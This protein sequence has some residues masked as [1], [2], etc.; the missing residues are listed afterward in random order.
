MLDRRGLVLMHVSEMLFRS[1]V[2]QTYSL[3]SRLVLRIPAGVHVGRVGRRLGRIHRLHLS[4][5]GLLHG[6]WVLVV[7]D[8]SVLRLLCPG[9]L[10][11]KRTVKMPGVKAVR[12]VPSLL[13]L[14]PLVDVRL[15]L[16]RD[17][18]GSRNAIL[19]FLI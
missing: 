5:V 14:S 3:G 15:V 2:R 9:L 8:W 16:G 19:A 17:G 10:G 4:V 6:H 1:L 7:G 11:A 13:V 18:A 12:V